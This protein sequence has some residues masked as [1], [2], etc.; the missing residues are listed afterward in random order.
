MHIKQNKC[1]LFIYYTYLCR[2]NT[3]KFNNSLYLTTLVVV[4]CLKLSSSFCTQKE[5]IIETYGVNDLAKIKDFQG[6]YINFGYW[7]NIS[8]DKK[9]TVPQR[10]ESSRN[11]YTLMFDMLKINKND[12]VLEIGCGRGNGCIELLNR[13]APKRLWGVDI[14]PQQIQRAQSIHKFALEKFPMLS[15]KISSSNKLSFDNNSFTKIYSVEAAQCFPSMDKFAKEAYRVLKKD[16]T[17]A[18]TAHFST[19]EEGYQEVRRLIPTFEKGDRLIPIEQVRQ[20]F[21]DAGF[22]EIKFFSIG[23]YVFKSLDQWLEQIDAISWVRNFYQCYNKG[24]L[25]YYV[26]VFKK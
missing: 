13:I 26:L 22:T 9:I 10:I 11:L 7:K 16:G 17:V 6:G 4:I 14:T 12:E 20:S 8:W 3:M 18:I 1:I 21:K 2:G 24:Y 23:A 5:N 25:D 15:F 19:T